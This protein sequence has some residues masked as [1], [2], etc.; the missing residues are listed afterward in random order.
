[1]RKM[2]EKCD[3]GLKQ[4]RRLASALFEGGSLYSGAE[5]RTGVG[6]KP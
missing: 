1:M 2:H 6:R 4:Y 5:F 3:K